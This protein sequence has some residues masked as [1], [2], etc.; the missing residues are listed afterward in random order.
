MEKKKEELSFEDN[1]LKLESIV[2]EL[3]SGD[4]PLDNAIDK[5]KEAILIASKCDEKLKN[6]EEQ[7]AKI[8]NKDGKLEDFKVEE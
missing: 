5:Y 8:L 6:A 4:V 2:K 7:I 1:L 3:E